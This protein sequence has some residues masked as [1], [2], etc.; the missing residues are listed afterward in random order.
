[1]KEFINN[2]KTSIIKLVFKNEVDENNY[3]FLM[4]IMISLFCTLVFLVL[5]VFIN[6]ITGGNYLLA[7]GIAYFVSFTLLY[8][9]DQR[10]FKAKTSHKGKGAIQLIAF[11]TVRLVGFPLDEGLLYFFVDKVGFGKLIGKLF[12]SLIMFVF[13]YLTNKFIIFKIKD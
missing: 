9:L 6:A 4:Y 3:E 7:N 2:L 13:N 1:M 5:Y 11:V 8:I 12:G 10:L